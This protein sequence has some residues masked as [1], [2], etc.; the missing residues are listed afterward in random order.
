[1][2]LANL[3]EGIYGFE[4]FKQDLDWSWSVLQCTISRKDGMR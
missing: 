1:M 2:G 4:A 3:V